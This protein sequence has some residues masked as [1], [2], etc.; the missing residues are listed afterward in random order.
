M[1][2]RRKLVILGSKKLLS[3]FA[4]REWFEIARQSIQ[5]KGYFVVALSG[6]KSPTHF[7]RQ[8]ASYPQK[9][10]WQKTHIFFVDERCVDHSHPESNYRMV[11][12]C[13]LD[14]ID[15]PK[16]NI[17]PVLTDLRGPHRVVQ[18][19]ERDLKAF[20]GWPKRRFPLFDLIILGIGDD[21]HI[22]S[23]FP[24]TKFF[25]KRS[26]WVF[27]IHVPHVR[28]SRITLTLGLINNA[29]NVFFIVIGR[30]KS[31]ILAR[32]VKKER[33]L[34][35]SWV[36]LRRGR[37]LFLVDDMAASEILKGYPQK[38]SSIHFYRIKNRKD[39][40]EKLDIP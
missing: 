16:E 17:H 9:S 39:F 27:R 28:F 6:G 1:H 15:I 21:G 7:Y 29:H 33:S 36:S 12:R 2:S 4:V 37:L 13:L 23:L 18:E 24:N 5:Q 11:R 10:L 14:H 32:V 31:R 34:P 38:G 22:A 3:R 26:L 25:Y 30:N 35:A 19:Y 40:L 8:L 20:F